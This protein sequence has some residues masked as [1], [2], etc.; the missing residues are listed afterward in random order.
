MV[1]IYSIKEI[2]EASNRILK[3]SNDSNKSPSENILTT[4]KNDLENEKDFNV[5]INKSLPLKSTDNKKDI[6]EVLEKIILETEK[7][8]LNTNKTINDT[9]DYKEK[10]NLLEQNTINQK[11]LIDY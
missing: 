2:L 8:Q 4:D 11:D 1:N 6:P 10:K 3:S 7:S 9:T 5:L